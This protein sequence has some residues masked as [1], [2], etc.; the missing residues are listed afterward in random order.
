MAQSGKKPQVCHKLRGKST[1]FV[2]KAA[3]LREK[4]GAL[5]YAWDVGCG[6][7]YHGLRNTG[8]SVC[9]DDHSRY[10][11]L[12]GACRSYG[13]LVRFGGLAFEKLNAPCA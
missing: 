7:C 5:R 13:S 1:N 10:A 3:G 6:W 12:V 11:C 4:R 8:H 2:E 9:V